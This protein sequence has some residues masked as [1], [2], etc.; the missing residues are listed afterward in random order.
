MTAT[1][2]DAGP[3]SSLGRKIAGL[4]HGPKM[5]QWLSETGFKWVAAPKFPDY[6]QENEGASLGRSNDGEIFNGERL[7]ESEGLLADRTG[8]SAIATFA[9]ESTVF[10]ILC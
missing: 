6:Y 1:I 4:T 7:G 3:V 8:R 10:P 5:A 2:E 9:G